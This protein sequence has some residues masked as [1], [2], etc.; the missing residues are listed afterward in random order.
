MSN[1]ITS[2]WLA[3]FDPEHRKIWTEYIDRIKKELLTPDSDPTINNAFLLFVSDIHIQQAWEDI[4][5]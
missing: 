4:I 5:Q 3:Q 2:E 1:I